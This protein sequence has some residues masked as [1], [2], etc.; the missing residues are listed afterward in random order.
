[1]SKVRERPATIPADKLDPDKQPYIPINKGHFDL[2]PPERAQAFSDKLGQN[3]KAQYQ[4][5]RKLWIDLPKKQE[6]RDYPLL[7]D[8]ELASRCNLACPMC[9]TVTEEFIEKRIKPFKKG[10]LDTKLALRIID[11]IA[12]KVYALRLSWVGEPT[13][14]SKLIEIATREGGGGGR[15]DDR[16]GDIW[17]PLVVQP[18]QKAGGADGQAGCAGGARQII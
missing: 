18:V 3:W 17:Q 4:E 11:E 10:L 5:Y 8:L 16:P 7:V 15:G 9:P 13:L 6:L 1:M 2:E 12:G 14:H